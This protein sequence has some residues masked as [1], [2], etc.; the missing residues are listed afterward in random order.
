[1][2]R[3]DIL[4]LHPPLLEG[5]F[6]HSI[7]KKACDRQ[8]IAIHLHQIRDFAEGKHKQA[9]DKPFG[10]GAGMVMMAEPIAAC[11][12]HLFGECEYDEVIFLTPDAPILDQKIA[13]NL[14]LKKN[15]MLLCGHYKGIDER[16]REKYITME[17]SIGDY[18]LTGGEIAAA[19]LTDAV[20]RLIP[21]V[22]HDECSALEDSFQDGLLSPPVYT[23]P[24]QWR[25]MTVPDILLSGH[26]A[27]IDQWRLEQALERTKAKRPDLYNKYIGEQEAGLD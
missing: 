19:V 1:M 5:F 18:V 9:D 15:L 10:G 21:G 2:T 14:S 27:N 17:L 16:I 3:F 23:R 11:M 25:G 7:L 26:K 13:N 12:D 8:V 24:A 22:I 6:N 4:T 20:A